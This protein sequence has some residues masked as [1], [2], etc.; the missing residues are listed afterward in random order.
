M[1]VW[2]ST[3]FGVLSEQLPVADENLLFI[4]HLYRAAGLCKQD[5]RKQETASAGHWSKGFFMFGGN[6]LD[7]EAVLAYHPNPQCRKERP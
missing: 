2:I 4:R 3:H 1:Q 6:F 7:Q 5:H